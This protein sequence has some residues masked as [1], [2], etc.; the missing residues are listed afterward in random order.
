MLLTLPIFLV[1]RAPSCVM[2]M[3]RDGGGIGREDI[4]AVFCVCFLGVFWER[5]REDE[6]V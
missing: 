1:M 6:V 5:G 3:R 4:L 2:G